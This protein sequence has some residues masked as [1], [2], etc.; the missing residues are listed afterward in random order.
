MKRN[1]GFTLIELL[2]V[3]AIIAILAAILFPVFAKVREKARQT[4]CLSNE[5][6][7]GLAFL[8]YNEDYDETF[9]CTK[10]FPWTPGGPPQG[11]GWAGEIYPYVKGRAVYACPDNSNAKSDFV[12]SYGLNRQMF[13]D[14]TLAQMSS[15]AKTVYLFE[16]DAQDTINEPDPTAE[17]KSGVGNGFSND[18]TS[19]GAMYAVGNLTNPGTPASA[20]VPTSVNTSVDGRHTGGA[21][22]LMADGHAKWLK[23]G[24]VSPGYSLPSWGGAIASDPNWC[25]TSWAWNYAAHTGCSQVQATFNIF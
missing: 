1:Y 14:V 11:V 20:Q 22:Y 25:N 6:Q 23:P 9:P 16:L 7:V 8:Q 15:P 3:I 10:T 5:K 21:N 4:A 2:V 18:L 19:I 24:M 17:S 13:P 12:I